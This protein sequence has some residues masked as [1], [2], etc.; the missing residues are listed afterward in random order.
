[1]MEKEERR[2]SDEVYEFRR[3]RYHR[4]PREKFFRQAVLEWIGRTQNDLEQRIREAKT[5]RRV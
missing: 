3:R 4:K 1:M 2:F 5:T